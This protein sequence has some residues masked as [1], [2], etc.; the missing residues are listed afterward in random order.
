[1][2]TQ[3]VESIE[4]YLSP[5]SAHWARVRTT[6][7]D[8]I[9]TPLQMQ[10]TDY[11]R[12][13][14]EKRPYGQTQKIIVASVH[15]GKKW[16]LRASW[17][18]S[19][20]PA[21]FKTPGDMNALEAAAWETHQALGK[22]TPVEIDPLAV[23]PNAFAIALPVRNRPVLALMGDKDAPIHYLRWSADK[24]E[25]VSM[26]ATGIGS[27]RPGPELKSSVRVA[28]DGPTWHLVIAR[29][30]DGG[31]DAAPLVA[32]K[33]TGVGFALWRG[34]NQ[35]RAGIKAFSIDWTELELES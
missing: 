27:S 17:T 3:R 33:T 22:Q 13:S 35:E 31:K 26:I 28:A 25:A 32:G 24:K 29:P 19:S 10:P 6:Q 4:D 14:W 12:N 21:P 11:I 18:D 1:M 7:V 23:F 34:E 16:A 8:M 9:P 2:E 20:K 5:A 30:L 15:D